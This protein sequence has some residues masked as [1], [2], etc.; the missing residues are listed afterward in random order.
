MRKQRN[1]VALL[2]VMASLVAACSDAPGPKAPAQPEATAIGEP[3]GAR[4]EGVVGPNGGSLFSSD[5]QIT[6]EIPAGALAADTALQVEPITNT[7]WGGRGNGYR[8]LPHGQVFQVPIKIRFKYG[9]QEIAGTSAEA[10]RVAYQDD[11]GFWHRYN[12]VSLD[13]S[14]QELSVTT[15]HFSDWSRVHGAQIVPGSATVRAND[16]LNLS[17]EFCQAV[18]EGDDLVSLLARC[19]AV[20]ADDVIM[21]SDWSVNGVSG[22]NSQIGTVSGG[23]TGAAF[24]APPSAPAS[25]PVAVSASINALPPN[26]IIITS[27]LL[28]T[29]GKTWAGQVSSERRSSQPGG[30]TVVETVNTQVT[31]VED[32]AFPGTGMFTLTDGTFSG[33]FTLTSPSYGGCTTRGTKAGAI[34][35]GPGGISLGSLM[36]TDFPGSGFPAQFHLSINIIDAYD[37]TSDCNDQHHVQQLM[38]F[39][40]V[41]GPA[42]PPTPF[43]SGATEINETVMVPDA[44]GGMM[45][46]RIGLQ[47]L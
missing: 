33:R 27:N 22:G 3:L 32:V 35:R 1:N 4:V 47:Q 11:Q 43:Q 20:S 9:S 18:D 12:T 14:A 15:T 39:Q 25:N 7:A 19:E 24:T 37:G 2:W 42:I 31:F 44:A 45:T 21:A 36:I 13:T 34:G 5:A 6:V 23:A 38:G 41:S 40:P 8:L 46:V 16:T 30:V 17:V 29:G 26:R 10:L 28:I